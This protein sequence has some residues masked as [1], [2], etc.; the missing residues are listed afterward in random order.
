MEFNKDR[1]RIRLVI[2]FFWKIFK[3]RNETP[4]YEA[5]INFHSALSNS[6]W[7]GQFLGRILKNIHLS[8]PV[9]N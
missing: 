1:R 7:L 2:K 9:S 5:K 3:T 6:E 8:N 4:F